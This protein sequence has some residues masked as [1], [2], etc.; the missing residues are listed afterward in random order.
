MERHP[1]NIEEANLFDALDVDTHELTRRLMEMQP[2]KPKTVPVRNP[3][4]K[5]APVPQEEVAASSAKT[6]VAQLPAQERRQHPRR[7]STSKPPI[8]V[9]VREQGRS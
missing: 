8:A 6:E 5:P 9:A 4:S 1:L 3:L 2:V 7:T